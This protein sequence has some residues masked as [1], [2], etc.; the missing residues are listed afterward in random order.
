MTYS[1]CL[2]CTFCIHFAAESLPQ[3]RC[4]AVEVFVVLQEYIDVLFFTNT[5]SHLIFFAFS[6][7][8]PS[9]GPGR[10]WRSCILAVV[11]LT[12]TFLYLEDAEK[13]QTDRLRNAQGPTLRRKRPKRWWVRL[14]LN[15]DRRL[16]YGHLH[17]LMEEMQLEDVNLLKNFLRMDQRCLSCW[18]ETIPSA[19]EMRIDF[20]G[21]FLCLFWT[22]DSN[23]VSTAVFHRR[24]PYLHNGK[25]AHKKGS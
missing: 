7:Y 6:V 5:F 19:S 13:S 22:N 25:A 1:T 14:W 3:R 16:Q 17:C 8:F 20:C 4:C 10:I 18:A 23:K 9:Y 2:R 15:A 11:G 24:P 21:I 12:W